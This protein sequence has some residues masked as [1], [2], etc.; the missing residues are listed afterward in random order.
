MK[1][2]MQKIIRNDLCEWKIKMRNE[3]MIKIRY[4]NKLNTKRHF[5]I[6]TNTKHLNETKIKLRI[7]KLFMRQN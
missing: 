4:K 3:N 6:Q 5:K 2:H 7:N 1:L